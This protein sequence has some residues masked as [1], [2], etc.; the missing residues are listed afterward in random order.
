MVIERD[1]MVD[2][3]SH[4]M[5]LSYLNFTYKYYQPLIMCGHKAVTMQILRR[6]SDAMRVCGQNGI[7]SFS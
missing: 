7:K 3:Q 2:H 6:L 5:S 4:V 1:I